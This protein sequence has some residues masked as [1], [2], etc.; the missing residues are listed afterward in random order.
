MARPSTRLRP[1]RGGVRQPVRNAPSRART[2][3]ATAARSS[4]LKHFFATRECTVLLLDDT[5]SAGRRPAV[6]QHR[7]RRAR[8][9]AGTPS[10]YGPERRCLRRSCKMRGVRVSRRR[11]RLRDLDTGGIQVFPRLVAAEHRT[12]FEAHD[13]LDRHAGARRAAAAAASRAGA[14]PC[15]SARRRGARP[16][17]RSSASWPRCGAARRRRTT[18]STK[19]SARCCTAA[20][21]LGLAAA[22][23]HR[24]RAAGGAAR[25]TRPKCRRAEFAEHGARALQE[26]RAPRSIVIDS[27]NAY[28]QAMPGAKFLLLQMHEL[29]SF[30]EPAGR[31]HACWCL[32]QHG[33]IGDVRSDLDLSLPAGL[34]GAVP[35]LRSARQLLKAVS[36]VKSR[37]NAHELGI[38]EFRLG[39]RGVGGRPGAAPI[40]KACSAVC[41]PT[42][43]AS[44]CWATSRPSPRT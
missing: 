15:S 41:R 40:S 3:C 26:R 11:S 18:C 42:A 36:V 19:A 1:T 2:R 17:P 21:A 34:D 13:G 39:R 35:L 44:R 24:E 30:L 27:L 31:R 20:T 29:L 28:L 9:R 5:S 14:T 43:A 12:D 33:I 23:L 38:R 22:A 32:G 25:S 6:A 37:T 8:P 16:R 10:E 4:A 7:P